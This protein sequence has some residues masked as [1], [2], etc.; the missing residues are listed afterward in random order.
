MESVYQ[1]T[2]LMRWQTPCAA[3]VPWA[4]EQGTY[5]RVNRVKTRKS[6]PQVELKT[7]ES[8]PRSRKREQYV[9]KEG[10]NPIKGWSRPAGGDMME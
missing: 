6:A 10:W 2:N 4:V 5:L 8:L 9:R 7:E 3:E 1:G